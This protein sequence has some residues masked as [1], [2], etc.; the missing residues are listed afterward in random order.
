M[1]LIDKYR[2]VSKDKVDFHKDIYDLL[3]I[4]SKKE[5]IPNIIFYGPEGSGK[6]TMINIFLEMLFD[7]T[8]HQTKDT[9]Y[10]V[11]GSGSKK[12]IEMIQ[13]SN[14]HIKIV[15]K[16]NNYDRY[17][18]HHVVKEYAKRRSLNAFK[19][20]KSF[21]IILITNLDNMSY[22]A[23]TSLR[24]TME[25]YHDKCRFIMQCKSL[26]KVIDPLQSRCN[27]ICVPLP[28][29]IQLS[30]YIFKIAAYE[31]MYISLDKFHE[32]IMNAGRNIKKALWN[33]E[34]IKYGYDI[35]TDYYN[36]IN[37]IIKLIIELKIENTLLIRNI[38]FNLMIT[39]ISGSTIIKDLIDTI[40]LDK[41][42]SELSKQQIIKECTDIEYKLIKGRREII[43]FD[44]LIT[45]IMKILYDEKY[46]K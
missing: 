4:M 39:N 35:D 33:I 41:N 44:A 22:Y 38:I 10:P 12:K 2:P 46:K 45:T 42:I 13:Q 6:N 43:Q 7:E 14:Y 36:S 31:K 5:D 3:D 11:S 28:T 19:T 21:K 16:N 27:K 15:P 25:R 34:F 30:K 40:I 24:R 9:P 8:V 18:I 29:N 23:Q 20:T 37:V 32:I 17:L 26:S 1:F